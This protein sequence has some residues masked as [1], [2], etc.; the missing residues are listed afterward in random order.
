MKKH[1]IAIPNFVA[2]CAALFFPLTGALAATCNVPSGMYLNIQSAAADPTCSTI[3]VAPGIYNE[4]ITVNFSTTINGAQ[5]GNRF[6]ARAPGGES[7][8]NGAA[9]VGAV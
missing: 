1:Q 8:V 7:T 5:A 6:D 3:N 4:N 9:P 2:L